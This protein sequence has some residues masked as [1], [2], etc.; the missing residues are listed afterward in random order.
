MQISS[1]NIL[2]A[3]QQAAKQ[4]PQAKPGSK[5]FAEALVGHDGGDSFA[6]LSFKQT[7]HPCRICPTSAEPGCPPGSQ[8]D[9]RI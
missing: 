6:P 2:I 3:A 4:A 8:L 7:R 1:A 5:P 9:I